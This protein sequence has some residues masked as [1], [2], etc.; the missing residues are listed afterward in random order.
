M[1]KKINVIITKDKYQQAKKGS[2]VKV[3]S[4]YAF[5]YLIPNQIAELATKGRIKHTKMFE[6]IKQKK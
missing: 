3:S 5:N 2:I 6:D 1:K 4:G